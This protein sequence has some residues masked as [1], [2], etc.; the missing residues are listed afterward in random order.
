M[1][2]TK[3][4]I[5]NFRNYRHQE[6]KPGPGFNL[7]AGKNAQGKSNFIEALYLLGL[8]R[9]YRT[10]REEE[11]L[12]PGAAYSRIAGEFGHHDERF[13]LDAAWEA[14]DGGVVRKVIRHNSNPV[15]RLSDFI[16]LAPMIL[17]TLDDLDMVRGEPQVRRRALD[18][19]CS[20]LDPSYVAE[21]REY[22]KVLESRNAWL[23]S[24]SNQRDRHLGEVYRDR[25]A[26]LGSRVISGRLEA[27]ERL[28]EEFESLYRKIFEMAPPQILYRS[29]TG[30]TDDVS[31]NQ[32]R[33]Q[34][35]ETLDKVE[36]QEN[37]RKFTL[38]GP[39]RDDLDLLNY[40]G[41]LKKFASMGEI[42]S[43]AAVLRL[44]EAG[45]ISRQTGREPIILVDDC[46]NEFDGDR[47]ERFM[48]Y[49]V[50]NRQVFYTST[51]YFSYFEGIDDISNFIVKDGRIAACSLS[52][53]KTV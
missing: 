53:L 1:I 37:R 5:E 39:H 16:G 2:L 9:P 36:S 38:A 32:V 27:V 44:S 31:P 50:G 45:I 25:L 14:G 4:T 35:M 30:K 43:A 11:A 51:G 34:F 47:I 6:V 29:S 23:K 22:K 28:R 13:T 18:L 7:F 19:L 46:L 40:N 49:L 21:L 8:G 48:N 15:T 24:H 10:T 52:S 20:R 26:T 17:L 41:S 12:S 42:R 3:L 33:E